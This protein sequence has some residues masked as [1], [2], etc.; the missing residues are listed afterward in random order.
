MLALLLLTTLASAH[1][2]RLPASLRL[3]ALP[4]QTRVLARNALA[5]PVQVRVSVADGTLPAAW[6]AVPTLPLQAVLPAQ[7]EVVLARLYPEAGGAVPPAL[8][9][10]LDSVPGS[11]QARP[12]GTVYR[13]PF[14][15]AVGIRVEQAWGGRFSHR[16]EENR[17][18]VDFALPVG[19][20]VLAARRGTVMAVIDDAAPASGPTTATAPANLVRILHEDGSM[21]VYAHL[22]AASVYVRPGEVVAAGQPLALSGNSGHSSG[23]HLHFAVQLNRGLRL[24]SLPFRMRGPHGELQFPRTP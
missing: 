15:P 20:P 4:G 9:L 22:A 5:G 6:T 1:A 21:A 11:P 24:V 17:H 7:A 3:Q 2:Q 12:D 18:A 14:D 23:P 13:L 19:T 8:A 10:D 16:D